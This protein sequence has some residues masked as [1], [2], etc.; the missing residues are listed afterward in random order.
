MPRKTRYNTMST[1]TS[2]TTSRKRKVDAD[3]ESSS[4]RKLKLA[5]P[6]P[7]LSPAAHLPASCLA[8]ILNFMEYGEVRRCLLA[9]KIMAVDAARH[10]ETL[11]IMNASE[12]VP[13]AARRF[14]NVTEI[15]ILSLVT[16]TGDDGDE[17][18]L[19]FGTA[20]RSAFFLTSFPKLKRAFLGGFYW[21]AGEERWSKYVYSHSACREPEDHL[22]IFRGLV[23]Q[24]CG[25]F[26]SRSLSP[27][28]HLKGVVDFDQ[29]SCLKEVRRLSSHRCRRCRNV[30]ASFPLALLLE[31]TP[32]RYTSGLCL[33]YAERIE[34]LAARHDNPLRL[35]PQAAIACFLGMAEEMISNVPIYSGG[36]I[37]KN[38]FIESIESQGGQILSEKR[39]DGDYSFYIQLY[40]MSV[41]DIEVLKKFAAFIG[42]SVMN[43]L[44][45]VDPLFALSTLYETPERFYGKKRVLAQQTFDGLVQLGFELASKDFVLIDPLN[46]AALEGYHHVFRSEEEAS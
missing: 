25:A 44:S 31:N 24:F 13:S 3:D 35:Q 22:S 40:F 41:K 7:S 36:H 29:L 15:N 17:D 18:I 42:S 37:G 21:D 23:D 27:S 4:G 45:K 39:L 34:A 38:S 9:G 43:S 10:V 33:S 26:Q 28:L 20:T 2:T 19:S 46:E 11:N 16:P 14:A 12:L 8:A 32:L 30:I 6:S 1:P 5:K